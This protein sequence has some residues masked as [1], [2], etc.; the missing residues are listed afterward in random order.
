MM[1]Q[2]NILWVGLIAFYHVYQRCND[3]NKLVNGRIHLNTLFDMII[4]II[5][6]AFGYLLTLA[7]FAAFVVKNDGI[8]VGDKSAHVATF[9]GAQILY[10]WTFI[11][12]LNM[13]SFLQNAEK[14]VR[15]IRPASLMMVSCGCWAAVEY[16]TKVHKYLL[17]DNRH[18]AFYI[19]NK[20]LQYKTARLTAIPVYIISILGALHLFKCQKTAHPYFYALFMIAAINCAPQLLFELRYFMLP[21][22]FFQLNAKNKCEMDCS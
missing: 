19:W 10:C 17:A 6:K 11:A 16:S 1:R 18:I 22:I 8:V 2:T 14:I 5:A 7:A 15:S 20:I 4:D 21:V 13:P 3:F 12:V 9:H